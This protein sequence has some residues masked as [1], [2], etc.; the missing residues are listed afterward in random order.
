MGLSWDL[1]AAIWPFRVFC[2]SGW[3]GE[4][5]CWV[6]HSPS[7]K[8][9]FSPMAVNVSSALKELNTHKQWDSDCS[10]T[11]VGTE[12]ECMWSPVCRVM[13]TVCACQPAESWLCSSACPWALAARRSPP[14]RCYTR[15][16]A[17]MPPTS[18]APAP[19]ESPETCH[20]PSA[21]SMRDRERVSVILYILK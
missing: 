12:A 7:S 6:R 11:C 3:K 14:P 18:S 19:T 16:A 9:S 15:S 21:P 4:K 5:P 10:C 17:Q 13:L 2:R 1:T 8:H 20:D